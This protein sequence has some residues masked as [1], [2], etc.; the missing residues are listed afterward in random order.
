MA[1]FQMP[2]KFRNLY[3]Q[4]KTQDLIEVITELEPESRKV[5]YTIFES[6]NGITGKI[7][8]EGI[9]SA[10]QLPVITG[11]ILRDTVS[12]NKYLKNNGYKSV[13]KISQT[14]NGVKFA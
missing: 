13:T 5:S 8:D 4:K 12:L 11:D 1:S 10:E 3:I 14:Q 7:L 9:F 2:E 6:N